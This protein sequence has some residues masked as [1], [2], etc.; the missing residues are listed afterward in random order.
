MYCSLANS[1]V[2]TCQSFKKINVAKGVLLR[3]RCEYLTH[4]S[5]LH[6]DSSSPPSGVPFVMHTDG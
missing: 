1:N 5:A 4:G 3:D 2:I 6:M